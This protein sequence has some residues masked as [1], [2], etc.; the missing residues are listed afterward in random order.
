MMDTPRKVDLVLHIGLRK[1][2]TTTLQRNVFP[3]LLGPCHLGK[4]GVHGR[5]FA[6]RASRILKKNAKPEKVDA[7][8]SDIEEV[9]NARRAEGVATPTVV[10]SSETLS[11]RPGGGS[12]LRAVEN[13]AFV[14]T[15]PAEFPLFTGVVTMR[16]AWKQRFNGDLKLVLTIRDQAPML[17]SEYAQL[18]AYLL[19][20]SQ[21]DF[22]DRVRRHLASGDQY[23]NYYAWAH[24]MEQAVGRANCLLLR[25]SSIG[26]PEGDA[27]LSRFLGAVDATAFE[28]DSR[29]IT[30][31]NVSQ[32]SD[33]NTWAVRSFRLSKPAKKLGPAWFQKSRMQRKLL[34]LVRMCD[35]VVG[36]GVRRIVAPG[37]P[38]QI[39]LTPELYQEIRRTTDPWNASLDSEYGDIVA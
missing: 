11:G 18:S 39:R 8:L 1:T 10:I 4:G 2:A 26:T 9:V 38:A 25:V 36:V 5:R 20:P 24:A 14:A 13:E 34:K 28:A 35:G 6:T 16:A 31:A 21:H 12:V 17:A 27:R 22:E 37:R 30:N 7:L 33:P 23:L 29:N 3:R 32:K 19:H 15:V